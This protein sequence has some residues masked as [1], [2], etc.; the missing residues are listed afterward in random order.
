MLRKHIFVSGRVQ[1]VYYRVFVRKTAWETGVK[2]W[3][4]NRRDGRVEAV[5]E[6][7]PEAV[8]EAIRL[9]RQGPP[10][11]L[12]EKIEIDLGPFTGEFVDFNIVSTV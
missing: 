6:G 1:G 8:D 9:C 12:V 3:V 5:M 2:G 10:G 11:A 7:E 4:R